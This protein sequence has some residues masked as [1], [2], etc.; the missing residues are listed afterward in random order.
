MR[1]RV[2]AVVVAEVVSIMVAGFARVGI[3]L[4]VEPLSFEKPQVLSAKAVP[5]EIVGI[6]FIPESEPERVRL[7]FSE[8][9]DMVTL[10]P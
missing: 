10:K 1:L 7:V 9:E 5:E 6:V 4:Y 8:A 2:A 3:G